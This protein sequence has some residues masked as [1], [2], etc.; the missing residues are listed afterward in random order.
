MKC[1]TCKHWK[2]IEGDKEKLKKLPEDSNIL[3]RE[4][5]KAT[6][7]EDGIET[8]IAGTYNEHLEVTLYFPATFG[9]IF[10]EPLE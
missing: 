9:C 7:G 3:A 8:D 10:H 1:R 4:C 5:Y 2:Q 6:E